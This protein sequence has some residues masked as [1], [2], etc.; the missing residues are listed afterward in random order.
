[1]LFLSRLCT[2]AQMCT[3]HAHSHQRMLDIVH[4]YTQRSTYAGDDIWGECVRVSVRAG[5]HSYRTHWSK[6][7]DTDSTTSSSAG[8]TR[9]LSRPCRSNDVCLCV[10]VCAC[11]RAALSLL[12]SPSFS[13]SLSRSLSRSLAH[14][15]SLSLTLSPARSLLLSLSRA[16]S[17]SPSLPPSPSLSLSETERKR[18]G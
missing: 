12:L 2:L 18:E 9:K 16:R 17:L 15:H 13:L 4:M 5:V 14:T 11:A 6:C 7:V 10:F 8:W 3:W 1:M